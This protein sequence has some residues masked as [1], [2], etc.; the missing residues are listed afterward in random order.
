[1]LANLMRNKTDK[2]IV[3]MYRDDVFVCSFH[4]DFLC[5]DLLKGLNDS[6]ET[7]DCEIQ[8]EL[9]AV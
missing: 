8:V 4:E 5:N 3:E 9:T 7:G 1:M 2:T 6:E